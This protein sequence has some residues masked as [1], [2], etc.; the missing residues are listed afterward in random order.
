MSCIRPRA[1][2]RETAVGLNADSMSMTDFTSFGSMA[3][4]SAAFAIAP[5]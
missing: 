1:P 5:S 4:D 3:L 2:L